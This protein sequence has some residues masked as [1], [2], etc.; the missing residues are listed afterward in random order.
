MDLDTR[1]KRAALSTALSYIGKNPEKNAIK[2]LDW[3]DA[4]AGDGEHS[5]RSQRAAFR[6]VLEDPGSNMYQLIMNVF[7]EIDSDVLKAMFEN[8]IIN[9]N[10]IG[11]PKQ[12]EL[13]EKYGCNMPG[14]FSW[15]PR[16]P[17][18]CAA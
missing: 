16:Q 14:P 13:R 5:L 10:V 9:A 4:A 8:F 17:A 18:T 15:T 3:V 11:T 6:K 2:L 12:A 1:L 7:H